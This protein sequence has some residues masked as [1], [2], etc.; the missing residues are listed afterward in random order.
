M[1]NFITPNNITI[2]L[3]QND[4]ENWEIIINYKKINQNYI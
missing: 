4:I 3:G 2:I 1:K